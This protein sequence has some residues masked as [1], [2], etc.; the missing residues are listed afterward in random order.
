[1]KD[2]MDLEES[3]KART[4]LMKN[5][6][7]VI[8]MAAAIGLTPFHVHADAELLAALQAAGIELAPDLASAVEAAEGEE[9]IADAIAQVVAALTDGN[10]IQAVISVAVSQNPDMAGTIVAAAV[11]VRP[12]AAAVITGAA[13]RSAP[14]QAASIV[15][16]AVSSAP[17][18]G[19]AIV[20]AASTAAPDQ[21]QAINEAA[22]SAQGGTQQEEQQPTPAP[23]PN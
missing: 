22:A 20:A 12:G 3:A 4:L 19:G 1:M 18:Q 8:A 7:K 15:A 9:A 6:I 11:S 5:S 17:T 21:T 10:V 2:R 16:A 14:M 13:V 23:S